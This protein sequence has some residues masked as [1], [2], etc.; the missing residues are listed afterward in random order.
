MPVRFCAKGSVLG[1]RRR[2]LFV[3]MSALMTLSGCVQLLG[4]DFDALFLR[5]TDE[6]NG[7]QP[8]A[9][10]ESPHDAG[11][12]K[13]TRAADVNQDAHD[14][15]R[16]KG[17]TVPPPDAGFSYKG[18]YRVR[19]TVSD[20]TYCAYNADGYVR[21]TTECADKIWAIY[22]SRGDLQACLPDTLVYWSTG[23]KGI[24]YYSA[25]CWMENSLE[26]RVLDDVIL[27]EQEFF[28]WSSVNFAFAQIVPPTIESSG[29][30]GVY[31]QN[32]F[33]T[34]ERLVTRQSDGFGTPDGGSQVIS[35]YKLWPK[36]INH[37][38]LWSFD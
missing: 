21:T 3:A 30:T 18:S 20:I 35:F 16:P 28:G 7:S 22:E 5:E 37:S 4:T 11:L 34:P 23:P 29:H 9:S 12:E 6:A 19:V 14:D 32:R 8:D 38:Q 24:P 10:G 26:L 13:D 17:T 33:G 15:A 2:R 31:L 27:T 25:S 1:I 36:K